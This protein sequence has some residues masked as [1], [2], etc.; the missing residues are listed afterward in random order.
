MNR[1]NLILTAFIILIFAL[2]VVAGRL[3]GEG[4]KAKQNNEVRRVF[5]I[6]AAQ[7]Y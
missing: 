2:A 7:L 1:N 3:R 6:K 4:Q 5:T